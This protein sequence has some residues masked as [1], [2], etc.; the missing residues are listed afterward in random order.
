MLST[1]TPFDIQIRYLI[2]PIGSLAMG[3]MAIAAAICIYTAGCRGD[4]VGR[5]TPVMCPAVGS[6]D[7]VLDSEGASAHVPDAPS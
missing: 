3:E 1:P 5:R 2:T 6:R 4:L 7:S